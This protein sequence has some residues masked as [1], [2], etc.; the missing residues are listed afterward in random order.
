[1]NYMKNTKTI[2]KASDFSATSSFAPQSGGTWWR[3]TSDA[4]S[5]LIRACVEREF[6]AL[7]F[8]IR[9]NV[10]NDYSSIDK[11]SGC[12]VLHFLCKFCSEIPHFNEVIKCVLSCPSIK[13]F[14]NI[15]DNSGN[16]ALHYALENGNHD[17]CNKL[18]DCGADPKIKNGQG[19][20]ILTDSEAVMTAHSSASAFDFG[21]H[22]RSLSK[23][24]STPVPKI[25]SHSHSQGI[26]ARKTQEYPSRDS[27]DASN[28]INVLLKL[29]TKK[30]PVYSQNTDMPSALPETQ[31]ASV[32]MS[33]LISTD[34]FIDQLLSHNERTRKQEPQEP[35][36]PQTDAF[37]TDDF[38]AKLLDKPE[39]NIPRNIMDGGAKK[40]NSTVKIYGS[41]RIN[42]YSDFNTLSGG[43]ST[44]SSS[45]SSFSSSESEDN[46]RNNNRNKNHNNNKRESPADLLHKKTVDEIMN[47]MKCSIDDARVY[48]AALYRQIKEKMPNASGLERAEE[49]LKSATKTVLKKLDLDATRKSMEENKKNR[50]SEKS[51]SRMESD[52]SESLSSTSAF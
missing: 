19:R 33:E 17:L 2:N 4:S 46:N 52:S 21:E 50:E 3:N 28:L 35:Q 8:N 1:M 10:N 32:A 41:R 6:N 14:I 34:K 51:L 25:V 12:T 5:V 43:D 16:T 47:V 7:S 15:Q 39:N 45:D 37:E 13:S 36:E 24:E 49:M 29:N 38:I 30:A 40:N 23:S 22:L 18:I 20:F 9:N 26:F 11:R 48:K 42:L 31:R 27:D 44:D